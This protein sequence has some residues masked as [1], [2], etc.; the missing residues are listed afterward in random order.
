MLLHFEFDEV[1]E[2]GPGLGVHFKRHFVLHALVLKDVLDREH[3][4]REDW[5][6]T[7]IYFL[8]V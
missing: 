8:S 4:V 2:V 6:H 5:K 3:G 1:E 7:W